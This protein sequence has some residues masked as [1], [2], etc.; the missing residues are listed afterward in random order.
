MTTVGIAIISTMMI[1]NTPKTAFAVSCDRPGLDTCFDLG[2]FDAVSHPGTTCPSGHSVNYCLG[3]F[4]EQAPFTS[5][6]GTAAAETGNIDGSKKADHDWVLQGGSAGCSR[7]TC[8]GYND[9]P[10]QILGYPPGLADAE[11]NDGWANGYRDTWSVH[12][13]G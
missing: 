3:W 12:V 10:P 6:S 13:F 5:P 7:T 4:A 8:V 9:T 11:Y 2:Y 1:I